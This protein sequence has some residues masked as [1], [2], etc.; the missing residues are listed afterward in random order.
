MNISEI[1]AKIERDEIGNSMYKFIEELYPICRSIT[2]NGLRQT[3]EKIREHIPLQIHEVSTGTKVFDWEIPKEWNIKDAYVK[4]TDG[5]R[6]ID[7][8][9]SNL[10]VVNYSIPIRA[11]MSLNELKKKLYT[12]PEY[13]D[14]IPYLTSYYNEDWG[15]CLSHNDLLRFE[16]GEYKV[17]IDSTLKKGHLSYGELYIPGK[18]KEEV[19]I[20]CHTCHPS[21][22]NDNLSGVALATYLAGYILQYALRYSYRFLFIPG[23]IGSITWLAQNEKNV[24]RINYGLVLANVGDSGS[25]TYK[26]SRKGNSPI[27]KIVSHVL[28]HHANNYQIVEFTPYG[29]DERQYCSPGF[30]LPVG[31]L[32]RSPHGSYPEYHTS[33]DNL[34]FIKVK[35]LQESLKIFLLILN[36]IEDDTIFIGTNLKCEPQLGR[37]GIYDKTGGYKKNKNMSMFWLLNFADG[38]HSL[39]DIAEK[40]GIYFSEIKEVSNVLLKKRL[41]KRNFNQKNL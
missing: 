12:I 38:I 1:L 3:L 13:P 34:E 15:F 37:R 23:T 11:K 36:I 6:V 5:K 31:R 8:K 28:K 41:L 2:G 18:H 29:Y 40:S 21:L 33:A 32:T 4:N 25:F 24:G 17:V 39:L 16:E 26:K 14:W 19:L 20:S 27:D 22:C 30:N 7:F 9:K 10:H 35:S